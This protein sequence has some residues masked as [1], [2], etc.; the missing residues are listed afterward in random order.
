ME[1]EERRGEEEFLL[2]SKEAD[3]E[4]AQRRK[5]FVV[6]KKDE[7][8]SGWRAEGR[9]RGVDWRKMNFIATLGR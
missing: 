5:S 6:W 1:T 2:S 9:G 7:K 4:E 8:G 3:T